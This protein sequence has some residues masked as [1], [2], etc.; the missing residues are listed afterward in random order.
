MKK[1]LIALFF[2]LV[3]AVSMAAGGPA[4]ALD[5]ANIDLTDKAAMQDGL[6]PFAN[7]CMGWR[8]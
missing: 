7:Y 2:A 6:R 3:P 1:Q 4:V 5:E 8:L